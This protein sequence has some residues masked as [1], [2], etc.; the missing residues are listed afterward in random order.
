[1]RSIFYLAQLSTLMA[2]AIRYIISTYT[3]YGVKEFVF[4]SVTNFDP[5]HLGTGWTEWAKTTQNGEQNIR[6]ALVLLWLFQLIALMF[7]A[8]IFMA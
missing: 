7:F 8:D 2:H 5:N 1:M 3:V 6:H 4:L